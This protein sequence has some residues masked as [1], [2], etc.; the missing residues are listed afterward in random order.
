[1]SNL[2]LAT[3]EDLHPSED[4][5]EMLERFIARARAGEVV[6]IAIAGSTRTGA[7]VTEFMC[8]GRQSN[9]VL[10]AVA[11]LQYRVA[12]WVMEGS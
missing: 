2:R 5:V 6:G 9:T 11:G 8:V 12:A 1:M 4:L 10:A 7:I 3:P